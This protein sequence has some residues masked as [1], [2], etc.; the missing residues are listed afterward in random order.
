MSL[1]AAPTGTEIAPADQEPQR[2]SAYP[3]LAGVR[4]LAVEDHDDAREFIALALE[5]CGAAVTTATSIARA[6][7]RRSNA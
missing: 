7:S 3:S 1:P 6:R 2:V 5:R 4:V